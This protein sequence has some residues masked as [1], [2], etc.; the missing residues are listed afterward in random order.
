MKA[1]ATGQLESGGNGL[2]LSLKVKQWFSSYCIINVFRITTAQ[3]VVSKLSD[4]SPH[5]KISEEDSA[6]QDTASFKCSG[7][8]SV[9][10]QRVMLQ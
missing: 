9:V 5:S 4:H 8:S 3:I 6:T 7:C 1:Y 10:T 2:F